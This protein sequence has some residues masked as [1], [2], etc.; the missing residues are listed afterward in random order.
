MTQLMSLTCA[1][2]NAASVTRYG[3]GS[4]LL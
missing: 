3:S 1:L 2:M 4:M